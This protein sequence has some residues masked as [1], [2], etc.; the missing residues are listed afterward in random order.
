MTAKLP[1]ERMRAALWA[2][3]SGKESQRPRHGEPCRVPMSP[4]LPQ[5]ARQAAAVPNGR[6]RI[7][8][9]RYASGD[10]NLAGLGNAKNGSVPAVSID[11]R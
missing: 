11:L 5:H 9:A 6:R 8:Y 4:L 2:A 10:L 1:S 7:S 3:R